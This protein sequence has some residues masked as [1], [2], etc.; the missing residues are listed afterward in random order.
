MNPLR[1]EGRGDD[2]AGLSDWGTTGRFR[3]GQLSL[4]LRT[5]LYYRERS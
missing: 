1:I 3:S 4:E 2:F 5:K